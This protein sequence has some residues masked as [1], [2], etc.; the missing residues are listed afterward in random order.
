MPL[1]SEAVG[2]PSPRVGPAPIQPL[3]PKPSGAPGQP[4]EPIYRNLRRS[5][6]T[7]TTGQDSIDE[8]INYQVRSILVDNYSNQWIYLAQ[9][10][11][12]VQPWSV[13]VA[14]VADRTS[15]LLATNRAPHGFTQ[16]SA[17]GWGT[18]ITTLEWDV[19]PSPGILIDSATR[20][21]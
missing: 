8:Q 18:T 19:P 13:G 1:G 17:A 7:M 6:W 9:A 16:A 12:Y 15:R 14:L 5:Q 2:A 4:S 20:P 3:P 11:V 21:T 10:N